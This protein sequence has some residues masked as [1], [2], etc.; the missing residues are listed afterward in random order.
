MELILIEYSNNMSAK[1]KSIAAH[2]KFITKVVKY[3]EK[4]GAT[5][6]DSGSY[7]CKYQLKTI[8]GNLLI[9]F[10]HPA[11]SSVFSVYGVFEDITKANS[12]RESSNLPFQSQFNRNNGKYNFHSTNEKKVMD[13]FTSAIE[14][15]HTPG[16]TVR[17]SVKIKGENVPEFVPGLGAGVLERHDI[18][19]LVT[20]ETITTPMFIQNLNDYAAE[21]LKKNVEVTIEEVKKDGKK[22]K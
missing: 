4:I 17:F 7:Y 19:Y 3:L 14:Q 22:G 6:V 11:E 12:V 21:L 20:K 8:A 18:E 2:E 9:R 5:K 13:E 1:I 16:I 10:T 15:I